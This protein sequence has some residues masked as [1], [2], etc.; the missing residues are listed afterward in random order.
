[1]TSYGAVLQVIAV[2]LLD[3]RLASLGHP[4]HRVTGMRS[5]W[6]L[7]LLQGVQCLR[8]VGK[9]QP[10]LAITSFSDR[11]PTPCRPHIA[12]QIRF[13]RLLVPPAAGNSA[14]LL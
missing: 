12:P 6:D 1:M 8:E 7:L 2:P 14:I 11:F 13:V 3:T 5:R 10:G 9:S 4:G